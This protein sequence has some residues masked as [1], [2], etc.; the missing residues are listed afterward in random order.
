[1]AR[2]GSGSSQTVTVHVAMVL[3]RRSG[4]KLVIAPVSS[5]SEVPPRRHVDDALVKAVARAHRWQRLLDSGAYY[6]IQALAAAE[7]IDKSYISKI[8]RLSTLAPA[9]VEAILDGKQP[10]TLD[11]TR[12]L[13][14]F[15]SEWCRQ[16]DALSET[17]SGR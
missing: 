1:M 6:S 7:T 9:I 10:E 13:E 8:L 4:R 14:P 16:L 3:R 15:P 12:L 2:P 5:V 11:F 17:R